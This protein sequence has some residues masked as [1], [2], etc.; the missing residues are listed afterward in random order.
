MLLSAI[1]SYVQE[2][3][4]LVFKGG[5]ALRKVYGI[6]R[7]SDDLDFTLNMQRLKAPANAFV[8]GLRDRCMA[9]LMPLYGVAMHIHEGGTG[10]YGIDASIQDNMRRSA[11]IHI[12]INI[13]KVYRQCTEKRIIAAN[14]TYFASVMDMDEIIS[15]KIRAVYTRRNLEN[16]ARDAVDIAFLIAH[17]GRYDS[18]LV[19]QKLKET[20]H[21]PFSAASFLRRLNLITSDMWASDLGGIMRAVPD[22][23]E[24]V[25]GLMGFVSGQSGKSQPEKG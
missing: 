13:G 12:E 2:G 20:R 9:M 18:W 1:Y 24:T 19:N 8:Y 23:D 7:Y 5:T 15:E 14:T 11:K 17:G 21:A 10:Q 25:N 16:V 6:D 22:R 4:L 3:C